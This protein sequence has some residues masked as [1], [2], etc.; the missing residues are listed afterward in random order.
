MVV[1]GAVEDVVE[2]VVGV[3]VGLAVPPPGLQAATATVA[4]ARRAVRLRMPGIMSAP[5]KS[6]IAIPRRRP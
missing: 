2:T 5:I 1:G 4:S 6:V 3:G